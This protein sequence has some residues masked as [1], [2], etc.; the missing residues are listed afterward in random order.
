M[1]GESRAPWQGV[2]PSLVTYS[3][4]TAILILGPATQPCSNEVSHTARLGEQGTQELVSGQDLPPAWAELRVMPRTPF[5]LH[6]STSQQNSLGLASRERTHC[7]ILEGSFIQPKRHRGGFGDHTTN[8]HAPNIIFYQWSWTQ[9]PT[10]VLLKATVLSSLAFGMVTSE[11]QGTGEWGL[12]SCWYCSCKGASEQ[13]ISIPPEKGGIPHRGSGC[14]FFHRQRTFQP[15][16]LATFWMCARLL[17]WAE[18]ESWSRYLYI[19]TSGGLYHGDTGRNKHPTGGL[20]IQTCACLPWPLLCSTLSSPGHGG[21]SG[22]R[23]EKL[24]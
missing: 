12:V 4:P 20:W 9:Q 7:K 22:L 2:E 1:E 16:S 23:E 13:E 15:K 17:R 5:S 8:S 19:Y 6:I 3:V 18:L 14:H 10:S 11:R 24:R 21:S